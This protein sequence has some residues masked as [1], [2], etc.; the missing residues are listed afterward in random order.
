MRVMLIDDD[1]RYRALLRH[2]LTCT[3]P[4]AVIVAYNP[5]VRGPLCPEF[6]AQGFDAVMLDHAW[7]GGDGCSWLA[8]LGA[9]GGFAPVIFLAPSDD[10]PPARAARAAGAFAVL[11]IDKVEHERLI[12]SVRAASRLQAETQGRWREGEEGHAAQRFGGARIPGYRRARRLASGSVSDLYLAESVD[13]GEMVALK[14]TRDARR[15]DGVD[16][17][18]ERFLQEYEIVRSVRHPHVVHIH[19]LGVT[20]DYAFLVM[21]YFAR[22]DL[23]AQMR[24]GPLP[25]WRALRYAQE[26]AEALAAIH[27]AGILHRDLKPGN[28]MVRDDGSLALID[29]GLAKHKG[30][31]MEITDKGLIFGTPHYMSPEQGHGQPADARSDLYSLGVVLH[32]MLTGAK[33]FD[34]DNPMAI[35]YQHAKAPLPRL[36][37]GLGPLQPLLDRLLAKQPA[38]RFASAGEAQQALAAAADELQRAGRA[39]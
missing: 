29:F 10:S 12:A 31:Q 13:A 26:I 4:D 11:P 2:H 19:E 1:P 28:V 3:W 20:D 34:A 17:T 18:F 5:A 30:L 33:P 32:E 7:E 39:A 9:R 38:E 6:L 27:A 24:Q 23:R 35:I 14:V 25:A 8:E 21:E 16:Q 36:P 15:A 22:G 37:P